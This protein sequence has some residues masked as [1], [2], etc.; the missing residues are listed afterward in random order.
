MVVC[1]FERV[2][3]RWALD[4]RLYGPRLRQ[5]VLLAG[6][7][8]E[9]QQPVAGAGHAILPGQAGLITQ[10]PQCSNLTPI[11]IGMHIKRVPGC[12]IPICT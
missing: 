7:Y 5:P 11:F 12:T 4:D 9:T 6:E 8:G 10:G 1:I 2:Q 3:W